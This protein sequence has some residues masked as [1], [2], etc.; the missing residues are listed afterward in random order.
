MKAKAIA[1]FIAI[2]VVAI[3]TLALYANY[4][5]TSLSKILHRW[6]AQWYR[7]IAENGYGYLVTA[8][9]GRHLSD[10]AFFPVFPFLERQ[11]HEIFRLSYIYSGVAISAVASIVAAAG[12]YSIGV[13]ITSQRV[14]LYLVIGWALLPIAIVQSIAYSESLFTA[15]SVWALYFTLKKNWFAAGVLA[16]LAGATRPTGIAVIAAVVITAML[17]F[18]RHRRDQGA[19]L[20]VFLAPLGLVGYIYWV[21]RQLSGGASYFTVTQ[22][23]GN[24]IDGGAAF[25]AWIKELLHNGSAVSAIAIAAAFLVLIALLIALIKSGTPAPLIIYSAVLV[26]LSLVTSG[27]FGS[28]PRYLLPAF[29][30]LIPIVTFIGHRKASERKTIA[31][32]AAVISIAYGSIWLTG[33]GPL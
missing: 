33:S 30:L 12:I 4:Q 20:A 6:D 10:Y 7:R 3:S 5:G 16:S 28:K 8:A 9:D 26:A 29:P 2:K 14:A 1:S 27:Y 21:S 25:I 15:L 19:L 18:R 11:L 24:D 13:K 32:I 17:H 23:W 22:G 31:F